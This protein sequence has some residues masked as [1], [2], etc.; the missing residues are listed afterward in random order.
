MKARSGIQELIWYIFYYSIDVR[1]NVG[2]RMNHQCFDKAV[3]RR[4]LITNQDIANIKRKVID[5]T[6]MRHE[7]DA[8]SVEAIVNELHEEPFDPVLFYKPQ[9]CKSPEYTSLPDDAFVLAIQ[10]EWQKE[11][12][13]EYSSSILCIDSTHGTNA[14]QFKVITCIV[15]DDFGKGERKLNCATFM[16]SSVSA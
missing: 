15:P 9:H 13:E 14:Y 5:R 7:D 8:T 1:S 10:T 11:L 2:H 12:Y 4:H 16:L 3:K 6:I